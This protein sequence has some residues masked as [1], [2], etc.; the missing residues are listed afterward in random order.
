MVKKANHVLVAL[1]HFGPGRTPQRAR[2]PPGCGPLSENRWSGPRVAL[3]GCRDALPWLWQVIYIFLKACYYGN[4]KSMQKRRAENSE[5][6]LP[7][8]TLTV[9]LLQPGLASRVPTHC[10]P[11]PQTPHCRVIS[12]TPQASYNLIPLIFLPPWLCVD[13]CLCYSFLLPSVPGGPSAA[14]FQALQEC[15]LALQWWHCAL[16][17]PL[18]GG[19][20]PPWDRVTTAPRS[21]EV[22]A[23]CDLKVTRSDLKP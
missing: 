11:P 5:C 6:P 15:C 16:R 18:C 22:V 20:L 23:R 13:R 2:E 9:T 19:G 1:R 4:F 8:P 3:G 21:P 14:T 17:Q 10:S 7:S 12:G